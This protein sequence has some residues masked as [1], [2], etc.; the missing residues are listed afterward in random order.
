MG[1]TNKEIITMLEKLQEDINSFCYTDEN[2]CEDVVRQQDIE[3]EIN[4]RINALEV[5]N[6]NDD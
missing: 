5:D 2:T 3:D 1:M 6:G 4:E